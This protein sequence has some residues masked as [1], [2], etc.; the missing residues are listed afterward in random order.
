MNALQEGYTP[1]II[2]G[3]MKE[4]YRSHILIFVVLVCEAV[5]FGFENAR[6]LRQVTTSG[7]IKT[8]QEI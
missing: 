3:E 7:I 6:K 1:E 8:F 5:R 2:L 4:N